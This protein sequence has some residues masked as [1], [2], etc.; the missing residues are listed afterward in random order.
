MDNDKK[1]KEI[2]EPDTSQNINKYIWI[3]GSILLV[4]FGW[5]GVRMV[6][7]SFE[8]YKVTLLNAAN[9][10]T[11]GVPTA[12]TWRVDG[13][14]VTITHTAIYFGPVS[15]PG[16]LGKKV[17]PQETKYDQILKDFNIGSYNVPLQFVGNMKFDK[18]GKYYFRVHATVRNLNF[19]SDEY[20]LVVK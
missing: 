3:I 14:P 5:F 12:I 2:T 7:S 9:E 6:V 10:V 15:T 1:E 8:D 18:P 4:I 16:I 17:T 19:W 20:S 13:P 11:A